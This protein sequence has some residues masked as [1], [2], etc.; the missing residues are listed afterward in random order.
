MKLV[1]FAVLALGSVS[2][3]ASN[4]F[5]SS[6]KV[7]CKSN[8]YAVLA[9]AAATGNGEF[10]VQAT[11]EPAECF[12][13]KRAL[14]K[15]GYIV[16]RNTDGILSYVNPVTKKAMAYKSK[17]IVLQAGISSEKEAAQVAQAFVDAGVCVSTRWEALDPLR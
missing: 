13:A 1:F 6:L 10:T 11:C 2:A 14:N 5:E 17:P 7:D 8:E 4:T 3:L 12:Y 9:Q 16:F 15:D